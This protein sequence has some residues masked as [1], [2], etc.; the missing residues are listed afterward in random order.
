M[1]VKAKKILI[2]ELMYAKDLDEEET[3]EWLGRGP[4]LGRRLEEEAARRAGAAA[5]ERRR[6]TDVRSGPCSSPQGAAS[7]SAL[8]RPKAFARLR[9]VSAARREP[10]RLDGIG[11]DRRDR[12][13]RAARLGGAGDPARRGARLRQGRSRSSPAARA[14]PHRSAPGSPRCPMRPRL[15]AR[16]RRR[17]AG[18]CP[19]SCS[20]GCST[21]LA[22]GWDG[23][24]PGLPDCG[25]GQ[26]R[27]RRPVVETLDR[28]SLVGAQTPQAFVWP[29]LRDA[30]RRRRRGSD[31][32]ALV[33]SA[34]G[35]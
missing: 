28:E 9:R 18:C 24:V 6:P 20:S 15:I 21:A 10:R 34:A 8:D 7:D 31:C 30:A 17:A 27:R 4:R 14:A 22:E 3:A 11:L 19:R 25:H 33:E 5:I 13:R 23:V 16:P 26:A 35:A 1:F 29:V 2:S 12:R 32:A